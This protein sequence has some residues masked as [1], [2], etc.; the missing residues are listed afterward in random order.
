MTIEQIDT[1]LRKN[2]FDRHQVKVSFRTRSAFTGIFVKT[3]DYDDLKVK[4]FWRVVNESNV[5]QYITSKDTN[6]ARIFNGSEFVKLTIMES[7]G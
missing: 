5:K 3:E 7:I 1:F 2:N 4:N 6:L